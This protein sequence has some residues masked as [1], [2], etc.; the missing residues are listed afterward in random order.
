LQSL[1]AGQT[2]WFVEQQHPMHRA[3]LHPGA[4]R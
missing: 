3:P 1:I 4:W 2:Q